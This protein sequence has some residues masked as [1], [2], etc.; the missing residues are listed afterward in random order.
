MFI[1]H[2]YFWQ[3]AGTTAAAKEKL[4]ADCRMLLKGI[5]GVEQLWAGE[6]AGAERDVVDSSYTVGLAVIF[7]DRAAHD[8][9]QKHPLHLEFIARNKAHWERVLVYDFID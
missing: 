5:P 4:I 1:H 9:Y 7:A 3:K 2:V 6:P 8:F